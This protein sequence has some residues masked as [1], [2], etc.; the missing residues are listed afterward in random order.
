MTQI[1]KRSAPAK[2]GDIPSPNDLPRMIR[3]VKKLREPDAREYIFLCPLDFCR[4][5]V[6][7]QYR[8]TEPLYCCMG[9]PWPHPKT[10]LVC[11]NRDIYEEM[12]W[13]F[14]PPGHGGKGEALGKP[15]IYPRNFD[16]F[17]VLGRGDNMRD[18]AGITGRDA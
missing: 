8:A 6:R 2:A 5:A 10:M 1:L 12:L 14:G 7:M 4:R 15:I 18:V 16:R 13:R 17:P 11:E 3:P 9:G